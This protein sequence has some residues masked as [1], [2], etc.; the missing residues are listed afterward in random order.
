MARWHTCETTHCRA[1]WAI[2]LSETNASILD[3]NIVYAFGAHGAA[4]SVAE[5]AFW[6]FRNRH[7]SLCA[8]RLAELSLTCHTLTA[9]AI[10]VCL[11]MLP[12]TNEPDA[13]WRVRIDLDDFIRERIHHGDEHFCICGTAHVSP[14][15]HSTQ[16]DTQK[17]IIYS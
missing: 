11:P 8:E 9:I 16:D 1:G 13:G 7:E 17:G 14:Q 12:P 2:H 6:R 15:A 3:R 5:D 4:A 10:R